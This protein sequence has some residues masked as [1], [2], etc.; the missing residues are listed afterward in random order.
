MRVLV[1]TPTQSSE[2]VTAVH[3][4]RDLVAH[5]HEPAF[6]ASPEARRQLPPGFRRRSFELTGDLA[7]NFGIWTDA[8]DTLSP[9]LVLFADYPILAAPATSTPLSSHPGWA[10]SLEG[11]AACPVTLDH[12]GL[13]QCP[14]PLTVGPSHLG[15]QTATFPEL[16]AGMRVLL[17][18]PMHHPGPVEGRRGEPFRYWDLPLGVPED[19][20]RRVRQRYLDSDRDFLVLHSVPAWAWKM[21]EALRLPYFRM[22]ADIFGWYLGGAGRPV[23]VVSVNDGQL[24]GQPAA[25]G[26][27]RILNT[28]AMA[29]DDFAELLFSAD[30]VLTENKPSFTIGMAVCGL[31][32]CA[33]LR[34][35]FPFAELGG[36]LPAPLGDWVAAMEWERPGAVFPFEV[37]P[38]GLTGEL[39]KL[40]LYRASALVGAFDELEIFGGEPTRRR[41]ARLLTDPEA[42]DELHARQLAYVEL[43]AEAP[44]PAAL[45]ERCWEEW[46]SPPAGVR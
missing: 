11:L 34:N 2:T 29:V 13:G 12:L 24:L 6:L 21:A 38:M 39:D 42:R 10:G 1:V 31:R 41:L 46:A 44:P 30:L 4:A 5:G 23:V 22:L 15:G 37:F 27:V 8:L 3:V 35:S 26:P 43:L 36:C 18:C 28:T 16:P 33:A 25:G 7:A 32:P 14:E 9:Q 20:R 17:P 40:G 19:R 45:L